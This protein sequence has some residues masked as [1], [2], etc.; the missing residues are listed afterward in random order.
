MALPM[1][2]PMMRPSAMVA[3]MV[4]DQAIHAASAITAAAFTAVRIAC[5]SQLSFWN[6]PK[7]MPQFQ[8][9][10]GATSAAMMPARSGR[11]AGLSVAVTYRAFLRRFLLA[12]FPTARVF[13]RVAFFA[14]APFL[15]LD[16]AAA[17]LAMAF[18]AA[19]FDLAPFLALAV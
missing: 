11:L 19:F 1:A 9:P 8:A 4:R 17:F 10:T 15:A 3:S 14:L 5:A 6:Q 16:L 2:P 7:L 12:F 13:A 18:V